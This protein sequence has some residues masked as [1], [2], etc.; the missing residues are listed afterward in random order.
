M[1]NTPIDCTTAK[2]IA[3]VSV[4]RT[5][6]LRCLTSLPLP[7]RFLEQFDEDLESLTAQLLATQLPDVAIQSGVQDLRRMLPGLPRR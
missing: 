6:M 2:L 3:D 7:D 1:D 4:L 5:F